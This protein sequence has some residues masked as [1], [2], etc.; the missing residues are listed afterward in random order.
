MTKRSFDNNKNVYMFRSIQALSSFSVNNLEAAQRFYEAVL[1]LETVINEMGILELMIAGG[2]K[3]LVYPKANHLPATFTILNFPVDN[4]E[5]TVDE[6]TA[7][8]ISFEQYSEPIQT[9][10]K[11]IMRGP[12]TH[13]IAW[14]K[15][16]A[17]NILSV[18]ST[19]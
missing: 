8:G 15:D 4:V 12:G 3:I 14:F 2:N 18:V 17:G 1:G 6:L 16:P 10:K 19:I 7:K 5:G 11:G 13:Q 9:D